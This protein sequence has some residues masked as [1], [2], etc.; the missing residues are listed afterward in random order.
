DLGADL[1]V[2]STTKF[3]DGHSTALGGV[4]VTRDPALHERLFFLRKCT[5]AIQSPFQAWLTLQGV[6]TLPLRLRRQS[7]SAARIAEHLAAHP[8]V[9]VLHY[10][11]RSNAALASHQHLGAHGAVLSFELA[12]GYE[13]ARAF[14]QHVRLCRL[15]EHVGSVET[16]LTHSASMTH[17]GV[18]RE[19]RER[20]GIAEGLLRLSVGLEE[21]SELLADLDRALQATREFAAATPSAATLRA[22]E[23]RS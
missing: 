8:E 15:V 18:P 22:V 20:I 6:K 4:I 14:V 11:T 9:R 13:R 5:G 23:V 19:E 2:S 21:P 10:P 7:E 17:A 1:T 3:V 12:G 16:L